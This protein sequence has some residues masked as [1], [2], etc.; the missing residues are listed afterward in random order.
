MF[1][2]LYVRENN[3]KNKSVVVRSQATPR[4]LKP[5]STIESYC[6]EISV[7]HTIGDALKTHNHGVVRK[8]THHP[9]SITAY[10]ARL[11]MSD[12]AYRLWQE[13]K[14]LRSHLRRCKIQLAAAQRSAWHSAQQSPST[15]APVQSTT[16]CSRCTHAAD[17]LAH[18]HQSV[19]T[20]QRSVR[21]GRR[22]LVRQQAQWRAQHTQLQ[23]QLQTTQV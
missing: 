9:A 23:V 10:L 20:L 3:K 2:G 11:E 18:L 7:H 15:N 1:W 12:T 14:T 8:S 16:P 22:T 19:A 5:N 13:N 17:E 21:T 6:S 4:K